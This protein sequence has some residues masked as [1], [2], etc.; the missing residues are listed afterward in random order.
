MAP[1]LTRNSAGSREGT[2]QTETPA[3]E[4]SP[5]DPTDDTF[6]EGD[7]GEDGDGDGGPGSPN[8]DPEQE[9]DKAAEPKPQSKK[10]K[11]V[12]DDKTAHKRKPIDPVIKENARA[13]VHFN[14]E[15]FN[16]ICPDEERFQGRSTILR[17]KSR[18]HI[19][20]LLKSLDEALADAMAKNTGDED[21]ELSFNLFDGYISQAIRSFD[22]R[23][24][25][26]DI[27]NDLRQKMEEFAELFIRDAAPCVP[28]QS[29]FPSSNIPFSGYLNEE[30]FTELCDKDPQAMFQEFKLLSIMSMAQKEQ[31]SE[32]HR[33][34]SQLGVK[35]NTIH[36]WVPA[37]ADRYSDRTSASAADPAMIQQLKDSLVEKDDIIEGLK[38]IIADLSIGRGVPKNKG[39]AKETVLPS[40]E[41]DASEAPLRA[42]TRFSTLPP[43]DHDEG[44]SSGSRRSTKQADPPKYHN[45]DKEDDVPFE[46][47]FFMSRA[48]WEVMLTAI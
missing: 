44:T 47:C 30:R 17:K 25:R 4:D 28:F 40:I 11:V 21:P 43:D 18:Y 3:R 36:D 29:L 39:K 48:V 32:L 10:K 20:N 15:R 38:D 34:V 2:K 24:N 46:A 16:G 22:V 31:V 5:E 26:K 33:L 45:Q 23:F 37:L 13:A 6:F 35:M 41:R 1:R 19:H 8:P 42:S 7:E 14:E 12:I 27:A 9:K